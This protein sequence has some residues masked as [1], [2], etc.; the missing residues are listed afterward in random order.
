MIIISMKDE[1][2]RYAVDYATDY[3][4]TNTLNEY[5]EYF[6]TK[7]SSNLELE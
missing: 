6:K 5:M 7:D 3:Y 1:E 2:G 4:I